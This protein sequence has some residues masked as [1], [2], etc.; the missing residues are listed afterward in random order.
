[1]TCLRSTL[2][3]AGDSGGSKEKPMTY[4]ELKT[5]EWSIRFEEL[6]R[7]RLMMGSYRYGKKLHDP[8]APGFSCVRHIRDRI[9]RY[10]YDGNLEWL[11]DVANFAM[12]E[13]MHSQHPNA[14]FKSTDRKDQS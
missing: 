10:E 5:S 12:L 14:H 6:M 4:D 1:M 7:N 13:F 8:R 3:K 2:P 11:V 9:S